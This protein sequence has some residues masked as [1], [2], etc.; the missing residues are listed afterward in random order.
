MRSG[1]IGYRAV[2]GVQ[3]SVFACHWTLNAEAQ[4]ATGSPTAAAEVSPDIVVAWTG[5]SDTPGPKEL[6]VHADSCGQ[7]VEVELGISQYA[8]RLQLQ[9]QVGHC[10]T[11]A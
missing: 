9:G 11:R 2:E 3:T 10:V 8:S 5:L 6:T 7:V 1:T 4:G